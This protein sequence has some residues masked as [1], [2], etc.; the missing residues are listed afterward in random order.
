M[1]NLAA[2]DVFRQCSG[3]N[4][5]RLGLNNEFA[6][7]LCQDAL[8]TGANALL[9]L[10]KTHRDV[11]I[12][13]PKCQ[14]RAGSVSMSEVIN[15]ISAS[16]RHF[17][18]GLIGFSTC[19]LDHRGDLKLVDKLKFYL[20]VGSLA[21]ELSFSTPAKLLAFELTE[22][23]LSK[24]RKFSQITIHAPWCGIKYFDGS[25]LSDKVLSKIMA[26]AQLVPV[27]GV[28]FHPDEVANFNGLDVIPLPIL[29]ENMGQPKRFGS[30][31]EDMEKIKRDYDVGFVL[32]LQHA[33]EHDPSLALARE[34]ISVMGDKAHHLHASGQR[35]NSSHMPVCQSDNKQAICRL[36]KIVPALP[37]V[38]EGVIIAARGGFGFDGT[39]NDIK[40]E[41][42]YVRE[43]GDPLK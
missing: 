29:I 34:M 28:V 35:A 9:D 14:G 20:R 22:D 4:F 36:L 6:C 38:L 27:Q 23:D 16:A 8:H 1:E 42:S 21:I 19:C 32:D 13:E 25:G 39:Y 12:S 3:C 43:Q 18:R 26:L 2:E 40:E 31:I 11:N 33:Y 41:F 15:E 17:G 10:K 24:L 37:V 30:S 7:K 5:L